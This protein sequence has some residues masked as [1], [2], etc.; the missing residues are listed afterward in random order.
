MLKRKDERLL[1]WVPAPK[2]SH[3]ANCWMQDFPGYLIGAESEGEAQD[4][5]RQM[6]SQVGCNR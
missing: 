6:V 3:H 2:L 1:G 4:Q 5:T